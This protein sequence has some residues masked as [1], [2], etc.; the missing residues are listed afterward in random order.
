MASA[1]EGLFAA[2]DERRV[3]LVE[4]AEALD[5]SSLG[6]FGDGAVA[7]LRANATASVL[8]KS[9]RELRGAVETLDTL[10]AQHVEDWIRRRARLFGL[11]L[12]PMAAGALAMTGGPDRERL[13]KDPERLAAFWSGAP[14]PGTKVRPPLSDA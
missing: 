8:A 12:Q 5:P 10:D 9:V 1:S 4:D 6:A 11:V 13:E 14:V 7:V 2:A 3:L